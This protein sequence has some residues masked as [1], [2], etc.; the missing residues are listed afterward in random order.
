MLGGSGTNDGVLHRPRDDELSFASRD[1]DDEDVTCPHS[2]FGLG[3]N[4]AVFTLIG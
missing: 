1:L 4:V 2:R 3:T